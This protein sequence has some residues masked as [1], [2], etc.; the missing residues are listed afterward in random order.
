MDPSKKRKTDENGSAYAV[1][2]TTP[3]SNVLSPEVALKIMGDFNRDQL[4]DILK[5]AAVQHRDVLDAVRSIADADPA[6]RKLFV[7]GLGG[8]TTTEKLREVFSSF[9]ELEEAIVITDKN[10]GKPKG[11]GF[12]TFRHVDGAALA[13]KEPSKKIDGRMTVT[14]LASLGHSGANAG[15]VVDVSL[16]K[17]YVGNVPFEISSE[18]LLDYFSIYG[19]IEEGPLGFDKQPGKLKGFAFFVYK[20]EEGAR[21]SLVDQMKVIDGQQVICKLA[22]DGKRGKP[23]GPNMGGD[24][25]GADRLGVP[26]PGAVPGSNY[27]VPGGL[28]SYGGFSGGPPALAH[29]NPQSIGGTGYGSHG[30]VGGGYG[31]GAYGGSQF[32]G[33]ASGEYGG[34]NNT[35]SSMYR[36]PSSSTG[37][38][39]GGYPGSGN[40]GLASSAYPT[41]VHQPSQ[42]PRGPPGGMYQGMPPY[43]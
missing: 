29:Q 6:K 32:G 10:T 37:M 17:I 38:P 28:A 24:I 26:P 7:R 27:G 30:P 16:R 4:L 15:N 2:D 34:L 12:V 21:A 41:Q 8:D 36:L 3:P 5:F 39:S 31:A 19:E 40:Y 25:G 20:T 11:Y 9:G 43:Y 35:G 33:S 22:A 1:N 18:R 14:Q 42:G 13:L 23:G